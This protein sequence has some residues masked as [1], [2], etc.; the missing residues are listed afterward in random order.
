MIGKGK[1][2]R[3]EDC[4]HAFCVAGFLL[5]QHFLSELF[6]G[7]HL[8]F[9]HFGGA[10]SACSHQLTTEQALNAHNQLQLT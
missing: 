5:G 1:A 10:S 7:A 9:E 4:S 2:E 6:F 8:L 3:L